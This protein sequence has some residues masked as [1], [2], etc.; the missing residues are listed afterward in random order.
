MLA[1]STR[2][3]PCSVSRLSAVV[4]NCNGTVDELVGSGLLNRLLARIEITFSNSMIESWWRVFVLELRKTNFGVR[5][6][7]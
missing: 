3:R 2:E 7:S 5:V 6:E 4:E 1:S